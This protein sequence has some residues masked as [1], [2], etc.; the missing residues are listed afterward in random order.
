MWLDDEKP[1]DLAFDLADDPDQPTDLGPDE[2]DDMWVA[3]DRPERPLAYGAWL[4]DCA[5]CLRSLA[6]AAAVNPRLPIV[7]KT[8]ADRIVVS[9]SRALR[10]WQERGAL[11]GL[12][13]LS[14]D[15]IREVFVGEDPPARWDGEFWSLNQSL[16]RRGRRSGRKTRTER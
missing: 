16:S 11:E 13:L 6:A 12:L 10:E 14:Y 2:L 1:F 4:C 5:T 9:A 7:L 15:Y 3:H 8:S